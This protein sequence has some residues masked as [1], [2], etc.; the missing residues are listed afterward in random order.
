MLCLTHVNI[1]FTL[2]QLCTTKAI[3]IDYGEF[4][5]VQ[6]VAIKFIYCWPKHY[7]AHN[8][9]SENQQ[10]SIVLIIF[11]AILLA[12]P[13]LPNLRNSMVYQQ[14]KILQ[15]WRVHKIKPIA[16][17]NNMWN[18]VRFSEAMRNIVWKAP[19]KQQ[20]KPSQSRGQRRNILIKYPEHICNNIAS[21]QRFVRLKAH[22]VLLLRWPFSVLEFD[23]NLR[24]AECPII[25]LK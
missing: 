4:R 17:A 18:M 3:K 1:V 7:D 15:T 20:Q 5:R 19:E 23:G 10:L 22:I 13:Y 16:R 25:H 9:I 21:T 8:R 2:Y 11:I 12:F 14:H 6:K 24:V